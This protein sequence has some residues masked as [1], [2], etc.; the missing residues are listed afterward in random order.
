MR[1]VAQHPADD[2]EQPVQRAVLGHPPGGSRLQGER[3]PGRVVLRGEDDDAHLRLSR[4]H[5]G[6]QR[7]AVDE[8]VLVTSLH[9]GGRPAARHLAAQIGVDEQHVEAPSLGRRPL[10]A[11]Q[12]GRAAAR[13][14]HVDVGLCGQRRGE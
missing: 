11:A 2:G 9:G 13:R 12:R 10:Q 14:G 5:A 6:D 4:T 7:Y 1:L 8:P 3:G